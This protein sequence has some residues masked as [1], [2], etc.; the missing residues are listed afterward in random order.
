[1]PDIA[2]VDHGVLRVKNQMTEHVLS[3][4]CGSRQKILGKVLGDSGDTR[5]L[6]GIF[7]W[8]QA[9]IGPNKKDIKFTIDEPANVMQNMSQG[10]LW[11]RY[12]IE[13]CVEHARH[14]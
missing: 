1:M 11:A 8:K 14:G 7:R 5:A 6:D 9:I 3:R 2:L 13:G 12:N 10:P 4:V